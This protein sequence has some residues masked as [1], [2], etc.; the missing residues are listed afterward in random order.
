MATTV[1][2]RRL[3]TI[4]ET[5]ER[6]RVSERQV[7]R[8]IDRGEIPA[9]QLGGRGSSLRIDAAELEAWLYGD[10]RADL[11]SPSGSRDARAESVATTMAADSPAQGELA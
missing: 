11:S 7:R 4:S 8:L 2:T 5:A 6:L 1:P 3:L 10:A 9:L